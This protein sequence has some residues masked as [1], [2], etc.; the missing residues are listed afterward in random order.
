VRAFFFGARGRQ[1]LGC[2]FYPASRDG[3]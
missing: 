2:S 1:V 3:S